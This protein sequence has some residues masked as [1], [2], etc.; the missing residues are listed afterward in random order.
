[1]GADD[2]SRC[3]RI[4]RFVRVSVSSHFLLAMKWPAMDF[5]G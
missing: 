2:Y 5:M 4:V 3:S 1:M